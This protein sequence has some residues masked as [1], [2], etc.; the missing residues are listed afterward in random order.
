MYYRLVPRCKDAGEQT[1]QRTFVGSCTGCGQRL[2]FRAVAPTL[3]TIPKPVSQVTLRVN[4]ELH[5][6]NNPGAG[7]SLLDWLEVQRGLHG[8]KRMCQEG[9]CGACVVAV[10]RK[11]PL[12]GHT[13]TRAVDS[14]RN[15]STCTS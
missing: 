2:R 13:V 8:S 6:I 11:D 1:P 3:Q 9:G 14:V 4:G 10:S 15:I 7:M 5:V 12:S